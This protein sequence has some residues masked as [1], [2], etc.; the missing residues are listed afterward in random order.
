MIQETLEVSS[1]KGS[2]TL[3][4]LLWGPRESHVPKVTC[5][6]TRACVSCTKGTNDQHT[7]TLGEHVRHTK[8]VDY[9][10]TLKVS[11]SA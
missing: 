1:E 5:Q 7:L 4:N 8:W 3:I 2:K 9:K 11:F 10:S 6:V